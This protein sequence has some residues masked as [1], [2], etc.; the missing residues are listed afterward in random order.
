MIRS[1][2]PTA[3]ITIRLIST[4]TSQSARAPKM[5][6]MSAAARRGLVSPNTRGRW[7]ASNHGSR[8][9]T[10]AGANS[11]QKLE[12]TLSK[13]LDADKLVFSQKLSHLQANA[14]QSVQ[15]S[16]SFRLQQLYQSIR[17][18]EASLAKKR[19][20]LG[21]QRHSRVVSRL[22]GHR[23]TRTSQLVSKIATG[24]DR[25]SIRDIVFTIVPPSTTRQA[26]VM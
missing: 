6:A 11:P 14:L 24:A 22:L 25:R 4:F 9:R 19:Q 16:D 1:A 17:N 13:R 3:F 23:Q 15:N 7:T 10:H 26:P 18:L 12:E 5:G 20:A 2:T 21:V 8:S